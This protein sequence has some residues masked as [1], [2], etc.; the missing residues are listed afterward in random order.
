MTNTPTALAA[1]PVVTQAAESP[2]VYPTARYGAFLAVGA[3]LAFLG[4]G[5]ENGWPEPIAVLVIMV[6]VACSQVTEKVFPSGTFVDANIVIAVAASV[7][8]YGRGG[9]MSAIVLAAAT[10]PIW[11]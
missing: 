3:L 7:G 1:P 8:L 11:R 9:A 2:A 4:C 10:G 6:A 5:L